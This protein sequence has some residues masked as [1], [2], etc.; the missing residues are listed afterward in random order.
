MSSSQVALPVDDNLISYMLR[1]FEIFIQIGL[2]SFINEIQPI[3]HVLK[4]KSRIM[5]KQAML[6]LIQLYGVRADSAVTKIVTLHNNSLFHGTH[7]ISP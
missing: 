3:S 2:P 4:P 5:L 6:A 7:R 1:P